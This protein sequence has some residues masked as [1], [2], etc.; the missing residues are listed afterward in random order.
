MATRNSPPNPVEIL[1]ALIRCASVTP[2]DGG[3][4]TY[5]SQLLEPYGFR[6]HRLSFNAPGTPDVENLFLRIGTG[7]PHLCFAGHV[8]VVPPGRADDWRHPPFAGEL[9]DGFIFGR[10]AQD[11]KGSV[12]AFAAAAI[13]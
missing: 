8:D 3:A 4:F 1:Q 6:V 10:G 12:A 5:L 9:V 2:E 11:M 13:E 7:N